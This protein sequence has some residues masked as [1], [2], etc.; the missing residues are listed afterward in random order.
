MERIKHIERPKEKMPRSR[1]AM[2]VSF[3]LIIDSLK[4]FFSILVIAAPLLVAGA[5]D[6]DV[7]HHVGS[8]LGHLAA[9]TVL[10]SVFLLN[11]ATGGIGAVGL[12]GIGEFFA[13]IIGFAGWWI[14]MSWLALSGISIFN[15]KSASGIKV[16]RAIFGTAILDLIPLIN[17]GTWLTGTAIYIAHTERKDYKTKL[18]EYEKSMGKIRARKNARQEAARAFLL[19]QQA[20]QI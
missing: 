20:Q 16:T 18:L 9:V 7:S 11:L 6:V 15:T 14:L 12:A 1:A 2:M 13:I 8:T 5:V 19:E 17:V 10:G 3:A 4:I